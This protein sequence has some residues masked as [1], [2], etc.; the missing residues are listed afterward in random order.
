M[1]VENMEESKQILIAITELQA[2]MKNMS[3]KIDEISKISNM[4]LET[5]QRAKSAHNRIDDLKAEFADKLQTQKQ[6][7]EKQ[8]ADIEK[9]QDKTEGHQT[10][11]WRTIGAGAITLIFGIILF[12]LTE[13]AK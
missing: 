9:R 4:V 7:Y 13:G 3:A 11:L 5:D 1:E 2:N 6:D 12:F 8:F 10:W